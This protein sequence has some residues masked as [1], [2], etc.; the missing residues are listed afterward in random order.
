MNIINFPNM[1]KGNSTVILRDT[2]ED[3]LNDAT[4]ES[5]YLLLSTEC[6]ELFGDPEFGIR[7]K[8]YF[9]EQNNYILR[10]ILI[11]EI[12]TQITTFCPQVYL[13]RK[14]IKIE[15]QGKDLYAKIVCKNQKNFKTNT[16][17]LVLMI[18]KENE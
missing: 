4:S 3:T 17:N 12:Y 18:N 11:D 7:L 1:F 8:R 13:E 6:G 15:Q 10:D 2:D 14:N 9:Y 5:I 16:Y